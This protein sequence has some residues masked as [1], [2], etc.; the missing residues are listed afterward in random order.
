M[1]QQE[2][3]F[4]KE[5]N[6]STYSLDDNIKINKI[7]A[8]YQDKKNNIKDEVIIINLFFEEYSIEITKRLKSIDYFLG[9]W[10]FEPNS[11]GRLYFDFICNKPNIN[12][13]SLSEFII[14][15]LG[16][17]NERIKASDFQK[18]SISDFSFDRKITEG[19][20]EKLQIGEIHNVILYY[21]I[22]VKIWN[23]FKIYNNPFNNNKALLIH[24]IFAQQ[25]WP[26][27]LISYEVINA[28]EKSVH[29]I[30]NS[31][32]HKNIYMPFFDRKESNEYL[33][34]YLIERTN[35][36]ENIE[37]LFEYD[38][39]DE[40]EQYHILIEDILKKP[41]ENAYKKDIV[42]SK[43]NKQM[44]PNEEDIIMFQKL[45]ESTSEKELGK[46]ILSKFYLYN[47]L[48][49]FK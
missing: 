19:F 42:Y 8:S 2:F 16:N 11:F 26:K 33:E 31:I 17:L 14:L 49:Y 47:L 12:S 43:I 32:S 7:V 3:D 45:Y 48:D 39:T 20:L 46:L 24:R 18:N 25:V 38:L 9:T 4:N 28:F 13:S 1:N 5:V 10:V 37:K 6:D 36:K 27:T 41:L 34:K 40:S 35:L 23:H 44:M 15:V 30:I 21:V 22:Y 29:Q